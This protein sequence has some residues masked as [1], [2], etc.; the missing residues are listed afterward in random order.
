M[1]TLDG[2]FD[3]FVRDR[4]Q[5]SGTGSGIAALRAHQSVEFEA[6]QASR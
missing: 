4:C 1:A 3:I 2:V 6:D 5:Q